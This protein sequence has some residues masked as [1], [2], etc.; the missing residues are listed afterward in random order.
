MNLNDPIRDMEDLVTREY[1][2]AVKV[3]C[4][5][6]PWR[7]NA[8]AGWL[9]PYSAERWLS[10]VQGEDAIACHQ[11]LDGDGWREHTRQ[12][13]GAAIFRANVCKSPRNPTIEKGPADHDAVFSTNG[14]FWELHMGE[15]I[16]ELELA[17]KIVTSRS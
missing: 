17:V 2:P 3:P 1:P 6:C 10:A 14:E 13:R 9:G 5:D 16:D 4:N 12:C 8:T 15:P 11:T 7:R